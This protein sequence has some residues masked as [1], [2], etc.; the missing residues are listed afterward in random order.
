M[1]KSNKWT[2][3]SSPPSTPSPIPKPPSVADPQRMLRR[4]LLVASLGN[5]PPLYKNTLHSAGHTLLS[6]LQQYLSYPPFAKSRPHGNGLF[7]SGNDITLWQSPTLMN[8]SGPAVATAWKTFLRDLPN[9]DRTRAKLVVVHDEL[10]S[11]LGKIK[12]KVGG[13]ARGHN[14]LKSC[15]SSL[16]G[17]AFSRIGVGIGRP[18]SRESRD[19][20]NYVLKKMSVV[21]V[22]KVIKGV[23][24]VVEILMKM[25]E[26]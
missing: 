25:Q 15:V 7:S 19:V 5:P 13:S 2:K 22:Q 12:L 14:G 21:E 16:G 3:A 6:S 24:E 4:P 23:E 8:V 10:E 11:P 1:T 26:E 18:E 9:E 17:M 20:A